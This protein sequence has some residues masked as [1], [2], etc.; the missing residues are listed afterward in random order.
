MKRLLA[1]VLSF[2]LLMPSLAFAGG[3]K[4]GA[5]VVVADTRK[6]DSAIMKY[7]SDLYNTNITLFAVWAVIFTAVY[8]VLLGLIMDFVMA[9]IGID[10]KSRKLVEH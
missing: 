9:R 8:G 1:L 5:L 2:I 7:F 10:L 4:A 3:E 6:V